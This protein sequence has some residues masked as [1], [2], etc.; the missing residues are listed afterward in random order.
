MPCPYC[1][2][3]MGVAGNRHQRTAHCGSPA[4]RRAFNAQRTREYLRRYKAESGGVRY[5]DR[6]K[7]ERRCGDCGELFRTR[8]SAT[9]CLSC[10]RQRVWR[11]A[12]SASVATRRAR[13]EDR[14]RSRQQV[15]LAG[16]V[17]RA[18]TLVFIRAA[19]RLELAAL[20]SRSKRAIW[21]SA[22]CHHCG[23]PFVCLWTN[24]LPRWCSRSCLRA[25]SKVRRR[26]RGG[27]R[28]AYRRFDIFER[29]RWTCQLCGKRVKRKARVPDPGSPV[30]D[31]IVPLA[32]GADAGGV[33]APWNVQCA[34]FLCNSIKR[35]QCSA[36]ALF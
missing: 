33:D 5:E 17:R 16:S 22:T 14:R 4:C 27:G 11:P 10:Q 21:A 9:V 35:D 1:S 32:A 20:G 30:I 36:P 26:Q 31:H 13:A 8:H 7:V 28:V 23:E 29:D 34:H 6:Y 2:T 24:D 19:R 3:P 12:Q 18:E 15:V 25:D